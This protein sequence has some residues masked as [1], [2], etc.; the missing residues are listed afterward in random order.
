MVKCWFRMSLTAVCLVSFIFF[1]NAAWANGSEADDESRLFEEQLLFDF[2]VEFSFSLFEISREQGIVDADL[3]GSRINKETAAD[4]SEFVMVYF[5]D[6]KIFCL[7]V[8]CL[9]DVEQ[10]EDL[11]EE[12]ALVFYQYLLMKAHPEISMR[13]NFSKK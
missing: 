5:Q 12:A 4:G 9:Y 7:D 10:R 1:F 2:R 6:K 11:A 3:S 13:D 8:S